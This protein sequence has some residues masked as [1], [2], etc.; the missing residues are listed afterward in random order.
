M[1]VLEQNT[2]SSQGWRRSCLS[3]DAGFCHLKMLDHTLVIQKAKCG[4]K[5]ACERAVI[6]WSVEQLRRGRWKTDGH[7][8]VGRCFICFLHRW[9]IDLQLLLGFFSPKLML[10]SS[11]WWNCLCFKHR[12]IICKGK[13]MVS[14]ETPKK[15][16]VFPSVTIWMPGWRLLLTFWGQPSPAAAWVALVIQPGS[17]SKRMDFCSTSLQKAWWSL[18][19]LPI[20]KDIHVLC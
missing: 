4:K 5:A 18:E 11:S 20:S 19:K 13:S 17:S 3:S 2:I 1:G 9:S 16:L 7:Y 12:L 8:C 15:I 6:Y 14:Q 10:S